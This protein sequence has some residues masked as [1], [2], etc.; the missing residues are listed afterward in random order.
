MATLGK[1]L[2]KFRQESN[3][4]QSQIA[5]KLAVSQAAYGKWEADE[6]KPSADNLYKIAMFYNIDINDLLDEN[7]KISISNNEI[8]DNNIFGNTTPTINI[9]MPKDFKDLIENFLQNQFQIIEM[10]SK[11]LSELVQHEKTK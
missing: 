1:K 8:G 6:H 9:E 11:I 4:S 5:E 3:L 7:E 2:L 10:Q